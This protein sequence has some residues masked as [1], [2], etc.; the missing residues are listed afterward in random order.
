[1]QKL[2]V[3]VAVM[4]ALIGLLGSLT[5]IP[6]MAEGTTGVQSD[7]PPSLFLPLVSGSFQGLDMEAAAV[8]VAAGSTSL[9]P[10]AGTSSPQTGAYTPSGPEDVTQA[11]FPGQQDEEDG[12]PGPYPGTIVNR[13]LS[14]GTGNGVSVNSGK[15]AKS[16]PSF[17]MG[18]EGLNL[19]QQ[20][21]ARGGNQ[22]TV[23]PPDQAL[24]AGNGYVVEAVNDVLN[25]FDTTGSSLLVDNTATNIVSGFPRDVN[26]AVDLNSF[27]GYAPAID[28]TTGVRAEFVTDPS[29]LYDA[30]TQR[31]FVV[32]LTLD[33]LPNGAFTLVNHLDLAVSQ[34]PDPTGLWNIYRIDVTNDGTNTGG[35]NPGPYLGDYPHIGA[36][37]YGIYLTT[38]AY[39][40]NY[41]GFAGAQVYALS[42]AQLVAGAA[43]VTMQHIDTSGTVNAGSDDG[44]TQPGFTLWPAQSPGTTSYD[45]SKGG[46]EYF[47][48]SNAADEATHPVA[49]TGGDYT[50]NQL[51]VWTLKNTSSL[52]SASPSLSLSNKILSVNQYAIPPKQKQPGSG[53]LATVDTPQGYCINDTVTTLLNGQTGCWRFLFGGEPPH[54]EVISTPD[55][56]DTRMQQVMYA[57][58]KLWGALDTALNPDSGPQ[59]A[60]IAWY[61]INPSAGKIVM[62]GY[63]GATGYDFTYPAIGVTPSGRG[64]MAFTASGDTLNPSAAYAPI[65]AIVGVGP[66]D[67]VPGGE[68]AAQDDGFTSYKSQVGNPP[69]TRWGD[70]GAA[71]VD[72]KSIWIASEYIAQPCTYTDWG[73]P[74]FLGGDGDNLLGTCGGANH[75][76]GARAALANWSTYISKLTP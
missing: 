14:E 7:T 2:R 76:P 71:A 28:R 56:N 26:H 72:G 70:Y 27:F 8:A 3:T 12:S 58:G 52:D 49:G 17:E 4:L 54:D 18:F 66:W 31:F 33:S 75:V 29:C 6:A 10:S 50:S 43:N 16:K 41:G 73:G 22:F 23:E 44:S 30:A 48:S 51:I 59:R 5:S 42:K 47:L 1:M 11:E 39:P 64:I 24:C 38:N 13:S 61:I 34:T 20:R 45:L 53:T 15:K 46:T 21:Y 74:Y 19:Y 62:Q 32:V 60:G 68:G 69:R 67:I 57:N 37:A 25:V 9:I 63:L 36:D 35:V 40:W 55:S 65:D